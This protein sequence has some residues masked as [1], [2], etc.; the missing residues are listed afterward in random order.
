MIKQILA[1]LILLF[2]LT[3]CDRKK[4]YKYVEIVDEEGLFGGTTTKEKDPETIKAASDSTAYLEA[5]QSFCISLKVNRDMKQSF[6]TVYSTPKD[7]KLYNDKGDDIR[8]TIFFSDKDK[9]EKEIEDRIF[10][11]SN[12]I[13]ES[14]D[15][16]KKEKVESFKQTVSVDSS[17]IKDLEKYFRKRKDEF[18]NSNKTWYEPKNAPQ[19][20]NRNGIYLYFQTEDGIPSNLRFRLQYYADDWLFFSRVQFSIDGKAYDYIPSNTETDSGDGGYIWEWFDES[21]SSSDRELIN[22]LAN[23][24]TA[25]M[26]L[27]GTQYY[28]IKTISQEQITSFKRT[29]ELYQVLG[30]RY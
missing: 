16:N 6:G 17:K 18:S 29:L 12:T 27:I 2:F 22:A 4:S 7:F 5:Y 20:T 28:D 13:Q 14:V 11:M 8:N 10:S 1:I 19:Y 15:R 23:A 30:G 25:K 3:S 21:V 24:K 9:R 26:K